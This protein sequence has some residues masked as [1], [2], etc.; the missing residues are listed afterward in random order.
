MKHTNKQKNNLGYLFLSSF[1]LV[2]LFILV[3]CSSVFS[4]GVSGKIVDSESTSNPKEGIQDVE[5]YAYIKEETRDS[6]FSSWDSSKRFSPSNSDSFIGHTTTNSDGTFTIN[7]IVWEEFF[8]D[9]GKTADYCTIYLLFYHENYGLT[10]NINPAIIMSDTSANVVYQEITK[11]RETTILSVNVKDIGTENNITD[12]VIVKAIVPQKSG[13][14]TYTQTITGNGNIQIS[15]PRYSTG[16]T[17]NTPT[18]K[19]SVTQNGTNPKWSQCFFDKENSKYDFFSSSDTYSVVVEGS[20]MNTDVYVKSKIHTVPSISGQVQYGTSNS[21][22]EGSSSDDNLK[23]WLAYEESSSLKLYD[24]STNEVTTA[25]SGNGANSSIVRHGLFSGL[26][27]NVT[28]TDSTYTGKYAEL[29]AYLV[30]DKNS[31]TKLD[32]SDYYKEITVRSDRTTYDSGIFNSTVS[33]Y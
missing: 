30:V 20:T 28:W 4:A 33:V 23:V 25:S 32:T 14:T 5:V 24:D 12:S 31:S 18:I 7:K 11:I 2:T 6:D 3:S 13:S 8:P 26:A 21:T 19:I 22:N 15:Y 29:T 9:F 17:I 16:T 10:K 27:S 1:L